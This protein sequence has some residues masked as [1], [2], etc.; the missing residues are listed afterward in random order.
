M[1]LRIITKLPSV[2]AI[3]IVH[4][5]TVMD[6]IKSHWSGGWPENYILKVQ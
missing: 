6:T 3:E 2:K 5:Q 4:E 1:V